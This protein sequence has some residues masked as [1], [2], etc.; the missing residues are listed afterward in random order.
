MLFLEFQLTVVNSVE[1]ILLT[2]YRFLENR[3]NAFTF[4]IQNQLVT[5]GDSYLTEFTKSNI[6]ERCYK[7]VSLVSP[8]QKRIEISVFLTQILGP[9][10][11]KNIGK[12]KQLVTS[13][14]W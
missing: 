7:K 13:D 10:K 1:V 6:K 9:E 3:F 12:L 4:S 14:N 5:T 2:L 8:V 11:L